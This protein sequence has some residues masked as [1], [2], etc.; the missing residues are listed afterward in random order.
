VPFVVCNAATSTTDGV[1]ALKT[2]PPRG[3]GDLAKPL[4]DGDTWRVETK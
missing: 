4:R 1:L 2:K 3:T